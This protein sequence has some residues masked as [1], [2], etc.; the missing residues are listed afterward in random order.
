MPGH[1]RNKEFIPDDLLELDMTEVNNLDNL[2]NP[3]GVIKNAQAKCAKIFG[4]EHSFIMT[5]GASAAVM[6][7]VLAVCYEDDKIIAMRNSHISFYNALELSGAFPV[8]YYSPNILGINFGV[9]YVRFENLLMS[10]PE[11]KVVFVTNPNYEGLCL[12]IERLAVITHRHEKILIV[13]ESHGSHFIFS[14]KFPKTA[15]QCGADIV[16]NSLHKTLPCLTQSAVLHV[17]SDLVDIDRVKRYVSMFQTTS[18]SYIL[19]STIEKTLDKLSKPNFYRDYTKKLMALRE[20]LSKFKTLRLLTKKALSETK[21]FDG[22]CDIDVSKLT[23]FVNSLTAPEKIEKIL[24]ER[25]K[26]QIEMY[27]KHHLIALSSIADTDNGFKKLYDAVEILDKELKYV[28]LELKCEKIDEPKIACTPKTASQLKCEYLSIESSVGRVSG[29]YVIKYPP[30]VPLLI[31][32]EVITK[33]LVEYLKNINSEDT[34]VIG[35]KYV[36]EKRS[37]RVLMGT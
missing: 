16:I 12:D 23:F 13:D 6:A 21:I 8:Y 15:M 7:A 14:S 22:L 2:H 3:T 11:A 17:N 30:G 26:I 5:N 9:N 28:E 4:C 27:G 32:S 10:N 29:N 25:F 20:K 1:K 18:P 33:N 34:S 19:M 24:R 37:I 36:S 35:L 31:P